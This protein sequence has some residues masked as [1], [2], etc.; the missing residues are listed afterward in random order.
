MLRKLP[1]LFLLISSLFSS[2]T[3]QEPRWKPSPHVVEADPMKP[4]EQQKK[5]TLPEGFEIQLIAAEPD[6]K[7][8]INIAFDA[9]GRL[10]VTMSSEYPFPSKKNKTKDTVKILEDFGPDGRA[11]KIT[12][13]A[14]DLNI[15]IG[16]LP[17]GRG[18]KA[19]I[20]SIPNIWYMEDTDGD[21]KA[22]IRKPLLQTYGHRDTHGMTGEFQLGFEGWVYACH[23]FSNTSTVKG[24]DGSQI[25]MQSGNTYRFK[26]DGTKVQYFTHGQVNPFGLTFDPLGNLFSTDCHTKPIYQLL[27]G[28]YY[29]SFGKPHDGL[30]FAPEMCRH[31]HGS[32]ALCGIT[33]YA[34]KQFPQPFQDNI[35][36]G[37]VLTN[38]VNRDSLVKHGSTYIA[39]EEED[40][41]K[42]SDRWFRPVDIKLGPDGA[43]YLADFYNRIFGHYEVP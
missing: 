13:F 30:G 29:P 25:T 6:I 4:L 24:T 5:F 21:S 8:P 37:N 34:A 26:P 16:V 9:R 42:C 3:A 41:V 1:F 10:W 22:D 27:K 35:F 19:I 39:K 2:A 40:L 28:G 14:D 15:P 11:R 38:R 33:Y 23:G 20:Y 31:T 32:T 18:N 17:L 36:I 12:T 43:V 7:N